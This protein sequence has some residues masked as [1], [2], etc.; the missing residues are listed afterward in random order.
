MTRAT[1]LLLL[2]ACQGPVDPTSSPG[3]TDSAPAALTTPATSPTTTT[4]TPTTATTADTAAPEGAPTLCIN[5]LVASNGDS[6]ADETGASP[7]WI[8]LHNPSTEPVALGDFTLTDRPDGDG[9]PPIDA[10]LVV[11]PGG[12]LVFAADGLPELGPTHLPF[13]LS[14]K[15]EA[16]AL[17]H[18]S[19]HGEVITFGP[20][21]HDFAWARTPDC[22]QGPDCFTQVWLG[23]PGA[24]NEVPR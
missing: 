7:D 12:F 15:G 24:S 1:V 19:G 13:A 16:V 23:T 17:L 11:P 14:E 9:V 6:W 18:A 21:Q 10:T 22:C 5:E 3:T 20:V 4:T 2:G 8:E